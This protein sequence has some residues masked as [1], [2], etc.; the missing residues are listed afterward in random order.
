LDTGNFLVISGSPKD[1]WD[2]K[3]YMKLHSRTEL[4]ETLG[5]KS[6]D[7]VLTIVGS[8]FTY[9][10]VWRE[11]AMV[12]KAVV[13]ILKKIN[14]GNKEDHVA[15]KVLIVGNYPAKNYSHVVQVML[16]LL[17]CKFQWDLVGTNIIH[18]VVHFYPILILK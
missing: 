8:P 16:S 13:P 15:V 5:F 1:V 17:Q 12:M 18:S 6:G 9:Q 10:G 3:S 7:V 14:E 4:R 11:H 2:V